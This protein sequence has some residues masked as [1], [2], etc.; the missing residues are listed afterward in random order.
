MIFPQYNNLDQVSDLSCKEQFC[1]HPMLLLALLLFVCLKEL[2]M[3]LRCDIGRGRAA[4]DVLRSKTR[5][6]AMPFSRVNLLHWSDNQDDLVLD[7]LLFAIL[8]LEGHHRI[9]MD[10]HKPYHDTWFVSNISFPSAQH[11]TSLVFIA[12]FWGK[13]SFLE[14][15]WPILFVFFLYSK[16][17]W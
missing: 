13:L 3:N 12:I 10:F 16:T 1:F 8:T 5:Y 2:F 6:E 11:Y 4:H 14:L 9:H 17:F 7:Q 15:F